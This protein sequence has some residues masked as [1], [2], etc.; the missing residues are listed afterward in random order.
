MTKLPWHGKDLAF[1]HEIFIATK[2]VEI[3]LVN[4][5]ESTELGFFCPFEG[6]SH[7]EVIQVLHCFCGPLLPIAFRA[8]PN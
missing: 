1:C 2:P 7:K 3:V 5:M 8:P 4:Q 6:I